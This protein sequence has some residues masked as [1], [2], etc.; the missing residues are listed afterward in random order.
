LLRYEVIETFLR[1]HTNILDS[2]SKEA[3]KHLMSAPYPWVAFV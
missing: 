3:P 2:R 1:P